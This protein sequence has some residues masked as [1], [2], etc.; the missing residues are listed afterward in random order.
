MRYREITPPKTH[1]YLAVLCID[2]ADLRRVQRLAE[3]R[4]ELRFFD[5]G[6]SKSDLWTVRV[7]APLP[8]RPSGAGRSG[9]CRPPRARKSAGPRRSACR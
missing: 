5:Y 6:D 9:P 8:H 2:P 1:P 4:P 3:D 7:E